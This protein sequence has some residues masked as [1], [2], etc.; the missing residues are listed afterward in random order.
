MSR[1][2]VK[3]LT[4]RF[5]DR[6]IQEGIDF[7]V[8]SGTVFA[9][10]GGSGC[11][12]STLLKHMIGLLCPYEGQVLI[13]DEDYWAANEAQQRQIRQRFGV[14]FQSAALWTS[15]SVLDNVI[16]PLELKSPDMAK[17]ERRDRALELLSWVGMEDAADKRPSDLSG[18]M[19]KRAGLARAIAGEPDFLFFDEPSAGLDPIS[20]VRLDKLITDLRDRTG[21]A[22]LIVSHELESLLSIADDGIFLDAESKRP[23]ARGKPADLKSATDTHP[24]VRAFLARQEPS[25]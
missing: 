9:I 8:E 19:K 17:A 10:M 3:N 22:V 1:L 15:M 16:V 18:G 4:M 11:G 23:I 6:L 20:S 25:S 7:S 2:D 5:G 14:L 21:A 13:D 24:T 12:K